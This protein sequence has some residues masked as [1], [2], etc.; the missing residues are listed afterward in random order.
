MVQYNVALSKDL[1]GQKT[2]ALPVDQTDTASWTT[3]VHVTGSSV[4]YDSTNDMMKIQS[5]QK[6]FRDGFAG[7]VL[8]TT[9]SWTQVQTGA[10][11]AVAVANSVLTI[12]TGTTIN[13]ETIL[14]TKDTFTI[15]FR[16][17]F[18]IQ[19]SQRIANQEFYLE[20]VSVDPV[21]GVTDSLAAAA[22]KLDGTN[23]STGIYQVTSGGQARLDSGAS[24]ISSTATTAIKE[25]E[26]FSDETWFHDRLLDNSGGRAFSYVR[27]Q[28]IP[29]PNK[30]YRVRLRA[31][32]LGTAPAS[33]T[34][35][36]VQY[37]TVIDYSELTTEITAS[38][39]G[40]AAG[41]AMPVQV[42]NSVSIAGNPAVVGNVAHDGVAAGNPVRLAGKAVN[43]MPT[44][45]STTGDVHD[46]ITTMQGALVVREHCIPEQ[47]WSYTGTP[48]INT[49][50]VVAKAAGAA[51]IRNYVN[52]FQ[53][54]NTNA[55]ATEIVIKDG[56]TVIWRGY[57]SASMAVP[58]NITFDQPL[59]GTAATALNVACIT[60]AANVYM[61]V[62]GYQSV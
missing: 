32:N 43:V 54:Q 19:L 39:G 23:A 30:K 15:P 29:D 21:T 10:G 31:K 20:L 50:D 36:T 28:R 51:G 1:D 5:T 40:A 52:G 53:Y 25:I 3:P 12:T 59:R 56:A 45:V 4:A 55:T 58:A 47:S 17:M 27:H 22:W 35:L 13:A 38:R 33:T 46:L 60:T 8:D 41:M 44:T 37:V 7:S 57:A 11:Q 48:I 2:T 18:G 61:N 26:C 49:T 62:Q 6:K 16:A 42:A 9:K 24:T 14:E 34:T